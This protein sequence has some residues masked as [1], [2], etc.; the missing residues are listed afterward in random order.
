MSSH[1]FVQDPTNIS[2]RFSNEDKLGYNYDELDPEL[3]AQVQEEL[4]PADEEYISTDGR[5]AN[6]ILFESMEKYLRRIPDR[7]ADLITLYFR[8]GMRQEQIGKLFSITQA[9]V[10]YR[11][12]RGIKRI[13]FLRTIPELN[14]ADF[15]A[16]LAPH[17]TDQDPEILWLMYE[18]TCQSKIAKI[19]NLTQGRVRHRFFR[20]LKEIQTMIAA[21]VTEKKTEVQ[22]LKKH[23]ADESTIREAEEEVK[24]AI[25]NSKFS[26]YY[27][28]YYA[29]SDKNFNVLHEVSIPQ[30]SNRGDS[31]L[32]TVK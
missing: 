19:L 24:K 23:G 29:I 5:G 20:A 21:E 14:R 27:T 3:L 16:E 25:V 17:F 26:K 22:A 10:S 9:A 11:L 2:A 32:L 15:D 7:E 4:S 6:Q 31:V 1:I 13:Q 30:F 18:T 28:V 8:D 12:H